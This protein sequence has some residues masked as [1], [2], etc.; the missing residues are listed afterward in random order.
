MKIGIIGAM[1]IEVK[2]LISL[3]S[4]PKEIKKG[5]FS[6]FEGKIEGI[7]VVL[8]QCGIGKVNASIG[9]SLMIDSLG[10]SH[11]INTGCAGGFPSDIKVGDIIVSSELVQHDF[12]C[13]VFAYAHG[14]VPGLPE[15]FSA[16]AK[17]SSMA[18]AAISKLPNIK[19]KIGEIATGDQF[20]NNP[21]ATKILKEKF[22]NVDAVEMEGAAIAQVCHQLNTPFVIIRSISDIAGQ[23]NAIEYSEFVELA[24]VNSGKMVLEMIKNIDK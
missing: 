13:T 21:E 5:A 4:N 9:A 1:E 7:D 3:L 24:A 16:D 6:F 18:Q 23:E 22:P 19:S 11:I 15:K 10:A 20:M 12:D 14:Q 17:L 8:L 2:N